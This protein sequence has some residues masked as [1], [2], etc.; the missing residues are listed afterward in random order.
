MN[1]GRSRLSRVFLRIVGESIGMVETRQL[2]E[3]RV[4]LSFVIVAEYLALCRGGGG[5]LVFPLGLVPGR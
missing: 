4:Q 2:L 1:S 3:E 5:L